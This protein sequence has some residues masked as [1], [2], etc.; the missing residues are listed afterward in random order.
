MGLLFPS[1]EHVHCTCSCM[2]M[3]ACTLYI[4][5]HVHVQVHCIYMYIHPL[6][7]SSIAKRPS[8]MPN[9]SCCLYRPLVPTDHDRQCHCGSSG[10]PQWYSYQP[11]WRDIRLNCCTPEPTQR[12][13]TYIQFCM[14]MYMYMYMYRCTL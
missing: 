9:G 7:R 13:G 3:H 10:R 4:L 1:K 14:Y 8:S 5:V 11:D 2:Y 6:I 12:G